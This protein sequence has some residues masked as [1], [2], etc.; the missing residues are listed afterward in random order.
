MSMFEGLSLL[1]TPAFK[2]KTPR[3]GVSLRAMRA[4][5][6]QALLASRITRSLTHGSDLTEDF[7]H[8]R[9]LTAVVK[10]NGISKALMQFANPRNDVISRFATGV[11]AIES[12]DLVSIGR[13][14]RR[15]QSALES[16][17]QS[18]ESE[19]ELIANWTRSAAGDINELLDN[20][21]DQLKDLGESISHFLT[22]LESTTEEDDLS[23]TVTAISCDKASAR[24]DALLDVLPDLDAVV[25]DPADRDAMDVYKEKLASLVQRVGDAT[26]V[27]I[28]PENPYHL[29]FK[30]QDDEY[31]A[32]EGTLAELGYTRENIIQLLKKTDSL[33]DEVN[34]LIE[35]KE[36]VVSHLNTVADTISGI[37]NTVPPAVDN[38]IP[39]EDADIDSPDVSGTGYSQADIYH[40]QV[41]SHLCI[42]SVVINISAEVVQEL[43]SIAD[44]LIDEDDDD[45][46]VVVAVSVE[47]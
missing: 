17:T 39:E 28:D 5:Q 37:D 4:T 32:Q 25:S 6:K 18:L 45:E 12:L 16:F 44:E 2:K 21:E 3:N 13:N 35:R 42:L 36:A 20:A 19:P 9:L 14:D 24:L 40:H 26:G 33:I 23:V 34:G 29:V 7:A 10:A 22:I 31:V 38:A 43:L 27:A 47:D 1:K 30:D 11:P 8:L 46:D 15:T 41:S